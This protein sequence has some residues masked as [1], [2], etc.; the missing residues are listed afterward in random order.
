LDVSYGLSRLGLPAAAS[1]RRWTRLALGSRR[2]ATVIALR[3]VGEA[4]GRQLNQQFRGRD[5]ATNVLSFPA[6]VAG[7]KGAPLILGDIAICAPVVLR[8]AVEQG[9]P[10]RAHFAHMSLHGVLHLLGH[11]HQQEAEAERMEAIER[12]LMRELG[13]ADPY[14]DPL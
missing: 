3:L 10:A 5:Y 4:E 9:K 1:F 11:D 2:R 14:L 12:R 13:F 8:E 6:D 7:L